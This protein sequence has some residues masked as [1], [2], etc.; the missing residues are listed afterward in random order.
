M[1]IEVDSIRE[2]DW[3]NPSEPVVDQMV[4]D[5]AL[6]ALEVPA[7]QA[8]P[9]DLIT[10]K[11]AV[12]WSCIGVTINP[13]G[14]KIYHY[15]FKDEYKNSQQEA[16]IKKQEEIF[17]AIEPHPEEELS[18]SKEL[19][20][21]GYSVRSDASGVY[22]DLPDL[23]AIVAG[24]EKLRETRPK[25][26]PLRIVSSEG[27]ADDLT[28]CR[29]YILYDILL[30]DGVEFVHDSIYHA[31]RV[32]EMMISSP[33]EYIASKEKIAGSVEKNL[34][35]F[36]RPR[37]DKEHLLQVATILGAT[38]DTI[39]AITVISDLIAISLEKMNENVLDIWRDSDFQR[40]W[41]KTHHE[42]FDHP[43]ALIRWQTAVN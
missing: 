26:P 34:A 33:E 32:L 24:Y 17:P 31:A 23:E 40:Y 18:F 9:I 28:F 1:S 7:V 21:I 38:V 11:Q 12:L 13:T 2:N 36:D 8:K 35:A 3:F 16:Y 22:L 30:S 27:I 25:C 15:K 6:R 41:M 42:P 14:G 29:A 4:I 37:I 10:K 5:S 43:T 39:W 19:Q 20:Q